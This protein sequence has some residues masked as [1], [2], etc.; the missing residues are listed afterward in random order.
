ML[1]PTNDLK[2]ELRIKR[3]EKRIK[4]TKTRIVEIN[5]YFGI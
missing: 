5:N 4:D 3:Y 1:R 2:N